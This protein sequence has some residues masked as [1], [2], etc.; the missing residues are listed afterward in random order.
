MA[1]G[2]LARVVSEAPWH[3]NKSPGEVRGSEH[4]L[5]PRGIDNSFLLHHESNT[6]IRA[7]A[8]CLYSTYGSY[9]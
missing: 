5:V 9:P 3:W 6:K 7:V 4:P 8:D 1:Y 2:N